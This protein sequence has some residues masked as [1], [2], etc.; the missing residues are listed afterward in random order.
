M[1]LI[2]SLRVWQKI[3]F[4]NNLSL[5]ISKTWQAPYPNLFFSIEWGNVKVTFNLLRI[6]AVL[7]MPKYVYYAPS[8]HA[9]TQICLQFPAIT[10]RSIVVKSG[11]AGSYEECLDSQWRCR[12]ATLLY[13]SLL[14]KSKKWTSIFCH[15]KFVFLI[16]FVLFLFF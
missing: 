12:K 2:F 13:F 11:P 3:V 4:Q 9:N 5:V 15:L 6:L 14:C 1:L 7:L 8:R 10:C 16:E